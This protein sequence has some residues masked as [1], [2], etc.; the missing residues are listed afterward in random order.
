MDTSANNRLA[1]CKALC[2]VTPGCR[3]ISGYPIRDDSSSGGC[4]MSF[5]C[6]SCSSCGWPG[7]RWQLQINGNAVAGPSD[8]GTYHTAPTNPSWTTHAGSTCQATA[9]EL[10]QAQSTHG[11][12]HLLDASTSNP[13]IFDDGTLNWSMGYSSRTLD[14]CKAMCSQTYRCAAIE[15]GAPS[16]TG[17]AQASSCKLLFACST[18]VSGGS[19]AVHV[20]G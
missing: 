18:V 20:M 5:A 1:D 16:S 2:Y 10:S 4:S 9:A 15:F 17:T 8:I 6:T 19:A 12:A 13:V 11:V 7:G 3:A 14:Q